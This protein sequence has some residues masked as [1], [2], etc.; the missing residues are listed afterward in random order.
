MVTASEWVAFSIGVVSMLAETEGGDAL[1]YLATGIAGIWVLGATAIPVSMVSR[2]LALDALTLI[3]VI[4]TM[5]AVTL[6]GGPGS[7]YYLL[8]LTPAIRGALFGGFRIALATSGLSS[9]LLLAI[10]L[11]RGDEIA[12]TIGLSTL[13]MIMAVTVAQIRRILVDLDT[14]AVDAEA[15][16]SRVMQR[17]GYLEQ[18][19]DLLARLAEITSREELNP[20]AIGSA[21]LEALVEKY[22]GSAGM[23]ALEGENGPIL[24]A[25]YGSQASPGTEN[26]I[27]LSVSDHQVGFIRLTTPNPLSNDELEGLRTSLRPLALSFANASILQRITK[28]AVVAERT[29]LARELHDEIGPSLASLGLSLDVALIQGVDQRSVNDHLAQ[30]RRQ[31]GDLVEEVR[32]TVS[33]LRAPGTTSLISHL[34]EVR[35]GLSSD[36]EVVT[37]IDE[38]KPARPSIT[39]DLYAIVTEAIR[40]AAS[41][42]GGSRVRVIGWVDYDRGRLVIE[43]DGKGFNSMGVQEGRFGLTGMHERAARSGLALE[44][45]PS[46]SGTRVSLEWGNS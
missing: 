26:L 3:G 36:I 10:T 20:I 16:S 17:L 12:R 40:N 33:D 5:T 6:T 15:S 22:P 29:R 31:V 42:S 27:P 35:A 37:E 19:N 24:V 23:A 38:R 11:A 39:A 7:G 44:I 14:R 34:T 43:D 45:T 32:T 8:S 2:A 25:R 13:Y 1:G 18:A 4:L 30:L 21:A 9:L 28:E 41:H 46:S